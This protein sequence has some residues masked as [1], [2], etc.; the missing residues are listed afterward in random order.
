MPRAAMP[1]IQRGI[2]PHALVARQYISET[3]DEPETVYGDMGYT[4]VYTG[5]FVAGTKIATKMPQAH[6]SRQ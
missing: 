6:P 1:R 4:R 2:E 3:I 5:A